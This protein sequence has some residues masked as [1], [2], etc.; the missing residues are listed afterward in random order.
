MSR[1]LSTPPSPRTD[2]CCVRS[3]AH[4]RLRV[5][6][7]EKFLPK[8]ALPK[9]R[10]P[11]GL[12]NCR[13]T[14]SSI[15]VIVCP[16]FLV[17]PAAAVAPIIIIVAIIFLDALLTSVPFTTAAIPLPTA[18]VTLPTAVSPVIAP[19]TAHRRLVVAVASS[20]RLRPAGPSGPPLPGGHAWPL[21]P[22][23]GR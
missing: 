5:C 14:G 9:A 10:A 23:N 15:T 21:T 19:M 6:L 4:E 12:S 2:A 11:P 7:T 1:R 16:G 22:T 17:T 8:T 3:G 13:R 18:I 20:I